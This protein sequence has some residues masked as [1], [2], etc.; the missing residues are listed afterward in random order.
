ME[1]SS[2]DVVLPSQ[3][4]AG[5]LPPISAGRPRYATVRAHPNYGP[6]CI[7]LEG[8]IIGMLVREPRSSPASLYARYFSTHS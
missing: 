4:L 3:I 1:T 5:V 2:A 8:E 6:L 7:R